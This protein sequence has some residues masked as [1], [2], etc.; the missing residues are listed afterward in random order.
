MSAG[1]VEIPLLGDLTIARI[2]I[3]IFTRNIYETKH[4]ANSN[5]PIFSRTGILSATHAKE[6]R[7]GIEKIE[8]KL[9][10]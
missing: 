10:N 7:K 3:D 5:S 6:R 2:L 1:V 4:A 8:K 9:S